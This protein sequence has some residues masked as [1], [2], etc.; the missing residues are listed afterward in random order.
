MTTYT[1]MQNTVDTNKDI[2]FCSSL[3]SEN[4]A[5]LTSTCEFAEDERVEFICLNSTKR[6]KDLLKNSIIVMTSARLFKI[7]P[8]KKRSTVINSI[9]SVKQI[10]KIFN[11][12]MLECTIGDSVKDIYVVSNQSVCKFIHDYISSRISKSKTES[13]ESRKEELDREYKRLS[14]NILLDNEKHR[15]SLEQ[16]L[17]RKYAE[18]FEK[19]KAAL[20]E[21]FGKKKVAFEE[22]FGKKKA[23]LSEQYKRKIKRIADILASDNA[24]F[25]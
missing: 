19:R 2:I 9:V 25:S 10:N 7:G 11:R 22:E 13:V 17:N 3:S 5:E 12:S 16:E 1:E 24:N 14:E 6:N 8:D 21:E 23:D 20:E 18:E 15:I 4:L